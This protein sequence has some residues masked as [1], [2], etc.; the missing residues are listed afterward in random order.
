ME[1]MTEMGLLHEGV[2]V[3]KQKYIELAAANTVVEMG[4]SKRGEQPMTEKLDLAML[5]VVDQNH[6][7][8]ITWDEYQILMKSGCFGEDE[9]KAAFDFLDKKKSGIID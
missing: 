3:D 9:A 6:E 5:D 2:K 1:V 8:N 4:K 7:G